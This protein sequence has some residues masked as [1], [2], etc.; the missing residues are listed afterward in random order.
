MNLTNILAGAS[1]YYWIGDVALIIV[2]LIFMLVGIRKGF[3]GLLVGFLGLFMIFIVAFLL[4]KPVSA[5]LMNSPLNATLT[6]SYQGVVAKS[7]EGMSEG[8]K[9]LIDNPIKD[10]TDEQLSLVLSELKLPDFLLSSI[11][12]LVKEALANTAVAES[13]LTLKSVVVNGMVSMTISAISWIILLII[14]AIVMFILKRFVKI[15][16]KI[17]II[18]GINKFL[19]AVLNLV[20]GFCFVCLVMGLFTLLSASLPTEA[21]D[22]VNNTTLLGW[23]YNNNPIGYV[24]SWFMD[25]IKI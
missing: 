10:L 25:S 9:V 23:F 3:L 15:F 20:I 22:Y 2:F 11:S 18:G 8:V 14:S 1:D 12:N 24:F 5:L 6:N 7:V 21:V 4:Y 16:N 13:G 17:P 19:G